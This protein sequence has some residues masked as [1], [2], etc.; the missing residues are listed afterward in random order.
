MSAAPVGA[1]FRAEVPGRC[2]HPEAAVRQRIFDANPEREGV[3]R[4]WIEDVFHHG[5]VWLALGGGPGGSADAAVDCVAVLRLVQRELV[6][7]P[8]ELVAAILQSVRPL[9]SSALYPSTTAGRR[10]SRS[11]ATTNL[12]NHRLLI[13]GCDRRYQHSPPVTSPVGRPCL[14]EPRGAKLE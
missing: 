13:S 10:R 6:A 7:P 1:R 9:I 14:P 4:L 11:E 12:D 8:I 3:T 2:P 5:P